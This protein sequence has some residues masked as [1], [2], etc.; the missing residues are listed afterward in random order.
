MADYVAR[1]TA[2]QRGSDGNLW[3]CSFTRSAAAFFALAIFLTFFSFLFFPLLR[4][5]PLQW[6]ALSL[7]VASFVQQLFFM[8]S[9]CVIVVFLRYFVLSHTG[10]PFLF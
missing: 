6:F 8:Q 3:Y 7:D 9:S 10:N 5:S 1:V 4:P 2:S